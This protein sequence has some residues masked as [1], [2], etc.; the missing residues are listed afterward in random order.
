MRQTADLNL[1]VADYAQLSGRS[2]SSFQR[3]FKRAFGV[4]PGSWLREA[5]LLKGHD[6]VINSATSISD[7]AHMVGYADTSH[8]I[9]AFRSKHGQTP[10]Q[11]R[12]TL[13]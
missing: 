7:I 9:K 1:S 13:T 6:L 3:D 2:V 5:R 4:A 8:F 11:L 12:Q 10:K